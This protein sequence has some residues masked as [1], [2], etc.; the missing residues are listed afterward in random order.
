ME[1]VEILYIVVMTVT[2]IVICGLWLLTE[3]FHLG[4]D[5]YLKDNYARK[6]T[7]LEKL[8]DG[9]KIMLKL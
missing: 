9:L 7:F 1:N 2:M 6:K 5:Y 3:S 8:F 4:G